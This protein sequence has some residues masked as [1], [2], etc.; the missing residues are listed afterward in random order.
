MNTKTISD[1]ESEKIIINQILIDDKIIDDVSA[2]LKSD[3]FYDVRFQKCYNIILSMVQNKIK[4]DTETFRKESENKIDLNTFL[5]VTSATTSAANFDFFINKIIANYKARNLKRICGEIYETVTIENVDDKIKKIEQEAEGITGLEDDVICNPILQDMIEITPEIQTMM[6]HPEKLFGYN[7]G[8]KALDRKLCGIP[9]EFII[10]SAR[11]SMG[12]TFL[13]QQMAL[14]FSKQK[15]KTLFIEYEMSAKA[16]NLRNIAMLSGFRINDIKF[17]VCGKDKYKLERVQKAIDDLA[18]NEYYRVA[19]PQNKSITTLTSFIRK[20][21]K[22]DGVQAVFI[23]HLGLIKNDNKYASSW[24]SASEISHTLQSLQR[25][26]DIPIIALSQRGRS[27][28]GGKEKGD[29]ST[30]RGSGSYE[31]DCDIVIMIEHKRGTDKEQREKVGAEAEV[32]DCELFISKNRN[33]STGVVECRFNMGK[34]RF[35]DIGGKE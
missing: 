1:T 18:N 22:K 29:L 20:S 21:V 31:E 5:D 10:L 23:D 32:V 27:A 13:A 12:K 2:K 8:I 9:K 33:N 34:G 17:G 19:I 4:I 7:T 6:T 26:L 28:E 30:I 35:Y 25:E 11:T 24:E 16:V 3:M 14:E 15:V